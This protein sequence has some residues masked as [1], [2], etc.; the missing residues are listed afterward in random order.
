MRI[1]LSVCNGLLLLLTSSVMADY[2]IAGIEPSRR[3]SS[4]PVIEWVMH[5]KA[6]YQNAL[7]GVQ[8]PYPPSLYFLDNQGNWHTPFNH[9]GMTGRYDF[10]GWHR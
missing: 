3:P 7:T 8:R 6:W 1:V 10:R 2:P 9:P 4:A 5:T